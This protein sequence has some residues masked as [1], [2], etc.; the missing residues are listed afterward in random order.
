MINKS[1]GSLIHSQVR[2]PERWKFSW[3]TATVGL[4]LMPAI[5]PMQ[6]DV[7]SPSEMEVIREMG[8]L[9]RYGASLPDG[10]LLPVFSD[11]VKV[12]T[13]E[14]TKLLGPILQREE[15]TMGLCQSVFV[16]SYKNGGRSS[17]E[18]HRGI[19]S[20][21]IASRVLTGLVLVKGVC[22]R[23]RPVYFTYPISTRTAEADLARQVIVGRCLEIVDDRKKVRF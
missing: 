5:V 10:L 21:N 4:P 14:S 2:R 11:N 23:T 19:K 16:P 1:N 7:N 3:L 13:S 20:V 15:I 8:F 9:K 17:C 6:G 12:F 22:V 18:I